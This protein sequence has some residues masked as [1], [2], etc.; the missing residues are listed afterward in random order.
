MFLN[1]EQEAIVSEVR[2]FVKSEI[3]PVAGKCDE[4]SRLPLDVIQ[5]AHA[6]GFLNILQ[7]AEY[8]GAGLSYFDACLVVEELAAG[9]AGITTSMVAN[10]LALL[11]IKIAGTHEQKLKFIKPIT[12]SGD[13][14]SFCLSEPG[15]GS[16]AAGISTTIRREGDNYIINGSK[17]WISNGGF[18]KQ[19]TVFGTTDKSKKHKGITCVIIP[20]DASG[21][22]RG[23]HE[24]KLGQRA[25]NTVSLTFDNVVVP[26]ENRIGQEGEGFKVAM[27]TLDASRP[28][29][30]IIAVGIARAAFEYALDYSKQ[31]K[32]FGQAISTFQAIQSMLADMATDIDAGR[33]LT[34]RSA[35]M[36]DKGIR[37]SLQSS[38]GKLFS[39]EMAMKATT[40][41]VQIFG[42]YGYTKDYPV[43]KLMRDA[44]LM[45]IYEGTSQ[46]QRLV[47]AREILEK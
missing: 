22:T 15:A 36:L 45:Q 11:P 5:K 12:E 18:A 40:D 1:D 32:Q 27:A 13:L 33:L 34:W 38:M 42:G 7:E 43:E 46:I 16:D 24:N 47:I 21:I 41:S 14:V 44:K 4:E 17:Q 31:R 8:G 10:D 26:V 30:A 29:T 20:G 19:F 37:A 25:S 39:A 28:M 23:H 6:L 3:I 2:K 35:L 9:C